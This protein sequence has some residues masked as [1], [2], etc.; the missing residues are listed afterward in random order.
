[1]MDGWWKPYFFIDLN[2]IQLL[3]P[4]LVIDGSSFI[5]IILSSIGILILVLIDR[6]MAH[7][8]YCANNNNNN[9]NTSSAR[10]YRDDDYSNYNNAIYLS[11]LY[12]TIQRFTS[13]LLMLLM[14]SF[15]VILF[16]EIILFSGIV[17][18]GMKIKMKR[19][20]ENNHHH[21]QQQQQERRRRIMVVGREDDDDA[22]E[23]IRYNDNS[24]DYNNNN[25]FMKVS[26]TEIEL[27]E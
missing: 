13:G 2:G 20:V 17:E 21:Q 19:L 4:A 22:E 6:F 23:E 3:L 8:Y 7:A 18:L 14:M 27:M 26:S 10:F 1:M 16:M 25:E 9:N 15:N 24:S 11:T 12:Y 5:S